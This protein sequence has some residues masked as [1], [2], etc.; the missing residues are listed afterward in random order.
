MSQ[1]DD[2]S[3]DYDETHGGDDVALYGIGPGA[4]EVRGVIEQNLIYDIMMAAYGW[5]E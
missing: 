5:T 3:I 1:N 4:D 2:G